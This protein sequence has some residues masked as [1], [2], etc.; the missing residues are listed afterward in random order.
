MRMIALSDRGSYFRQLLSGPL[1]MAHGQQ[2]VLDLIETGEPCLLLVDQQMTNPDFLK[3]VKELNP[4]CGILLVGTGE[5]ELLSQ[6]AMWWGGMDGFYQE[7]R[8]NGRA[9]S[10]PDETIRDILSM[11]YIHDLIYG[12]PERLRKIRPVLEYAGISMD[13]HIILTVLCDDFWNI[14]RDLDNRYRY[15]LKRVILNSVRAAMEPD[16]HGVAATLVGTDKIVIAL[17]CGQRRGKEAERYGEECAA[18]IRQHVME[19]TGISASVGI[20][21]YCDDVHALWR[22]YE[23]SFQALSGSFQQGQGQSLR[24]YPNQHD[25]LQ[26]DIRECAKREIIQGLSRDDYTLCKQA[27]GRF[28][29]KLSEGNVDAVHIRSLAA[30]LLS[31]IAQ[32]CISIGVDKGHVSSRL[33]EVTSEILLASTMQDI[34]SQVQ[35]FLADMLKRRREGMPSGVKGVIGIA[36]AYVD[37]Y[38]ADALNLSDVAAMVGY[39]PSYFSRQFKAY[40]NT[41]FSQYLMQVRIRNAQKQLI[42]PRISV[43]DVALNTGFQSRSYF[44]ITFKRLTGLTPRQFRLRYRERHQL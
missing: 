32:Y 3:K 16:I 9:A 19:D 41:N 8:G 34:Q 29:Q 28:T 6:P 15:R 13:P 43:D 36:K 37:Q 11:E 18:L 20:S 27:V 35:A 39:S 23:Q 21:D 7:G 12:H 24:Y 33:V 10:H 5:R 4:L 22:A 30:V 26:P 40:A 38:Y 2:D 1:A 31:E 44:N 14:C 17:E 42:D 25:S